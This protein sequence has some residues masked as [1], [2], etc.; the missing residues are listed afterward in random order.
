M[1]IIECGQGLK[2]KGSNNLI[3]I[4]A[5]Q[6]IQAKTTSIVPVANERTTVNVKFDR[7][8]TSKP[9]VTA[10]VVSTV[11]GTTLLECGVSN[12]TT[13]GFDITILRTNATATSVNWIAVGQI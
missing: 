3:N 4:S 8:F 2:I 9:V 7:Q 13:T 6:K 5:E 1:P 12:V 11:I 10:T